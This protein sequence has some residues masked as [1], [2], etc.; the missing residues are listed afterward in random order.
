M[1]P[2]LLDWSGELGFR[3]NHGVELLPDL[4]RFRAGPARAN[5]AHVPELFAFPLPQI[6]GSNAGRIFHEPDDWKLAFL[7]TLDLQPVFIAVGPIGRFGVLEMM[8]SNP[9]LQEAANIS[10]P[11]VSICSL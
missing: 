11:S 8:P 3:A 4:A 7:D 10:S 1:S 5:L 6:E 9:S 2:G